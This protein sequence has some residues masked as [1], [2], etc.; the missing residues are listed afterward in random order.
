[1][2]GEVR[3]GRGDEGWERVEGNIA[4]IFWVM[5]SNFP[6]GVLIFGG[7][8]HGNRKGYNNPT[9]PGWF[10]GGGGLHLTDPRWSIAQ[11]L[12]NCSLLN[13]QAFAS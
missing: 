11:R 13:S 1:M 3:A 2:E 7:L 8:V 5:G 10:G 12:A 9:P 4:Y 6:P